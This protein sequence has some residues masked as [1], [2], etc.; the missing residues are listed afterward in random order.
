MDAIIS[1]KPLPVFQQ[2]AELLARQIKAG[3]WREGER[4]PTEAELA[5]SLSVAVGTLRK[6]LAILEDEG[7]LERVQGSGTYVKKV[8]SKQR[9]YELFRLELHAGPGLPT[10]RIMDV[11]HVVP[12]AHI[13]DLG[14][15]GS[16]K[17]WRVRRMRFLNDVPIALEEIWFE[18][19][20][21]KKLTAAELG[22]AM[23]LFYQQRF[24]I[25]ISRVQD[26]IKVAPTPEWVG[27]PL[28]L[29]AGQSAGFI[30][31]LSW[32]VN[33]RLAEYSET[34]FDPAVCHYASRLSQ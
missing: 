11:S 12:P 22:D 1:A 23:Y 6:A 3:H 17:L 29:S 16:K 28:G 20:G 31:R 25:W 19:A 15:G 30:Q 2:I 9:I 34:W 8:S 26:S 21:C 18:G 14:E 24:Q 4:L 5:A 27:A 33:N 7:V 32:A 10:A 13:P